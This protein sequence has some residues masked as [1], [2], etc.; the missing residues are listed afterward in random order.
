MERSSTQRGGEPAL[1]PLLWAVVASSGFPGFCGRR[2]LFYFV[3]RVQSLR[4]VG[5]THVLVTLI[6]IMIASARVMS[7]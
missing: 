3:L 6:S 5:D 1:C 7:I 2:I 4:L